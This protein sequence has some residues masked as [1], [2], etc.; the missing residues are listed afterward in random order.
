MRKEKFGLIAFLLLEMHQQTSPSRAAV[1]I[2]NQ[3]QFALDLRP[4]LCRHQVCDDIK[5]QFIEWKQF[6]ISEII[7][8]N[9]QTAEPRSEEATS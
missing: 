2:K 4:C 8:N 6:F 1:E 9:A 5:M 3:F 7:K